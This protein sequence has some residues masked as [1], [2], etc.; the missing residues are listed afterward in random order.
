MVGGIIVKLG[1]DRCARL[2]YTIA[3]LGEVAPKVFTAVRRKH[4]AFGESLQRRD[5]GSGGTGTRFESP[6]LRLPA[7][8]RIIR[9]MDDEEVVFWRYFI[10][11][12]VGGGRTGG[13]P[14]IVHRDNPIKTMMDSLGEGHPRFRKV[15]RRMVLNVLDR[16]P[17]VRWTDGRTIWPNEGG[18]FLNP[19]TGEPLVQPETQVNNRM[20]ILE[21]GSLLMQNFAHLHQNFRPKDDPSRQIPI[22]Q[23]DVK[24]TT[25]GS[26]KDTKRF[27]VATDVWGPLPK[28]L[29][30]L[31]R[32]DLKEVTKPMPNESVQR[33][34]D[35]DD[36]SDVLRDLGW[37]RVQPLW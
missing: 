28:E 27:A 29:A 17:I 6:Y 7:G 13:K 9:I 16:T 15:E 32:Y 3:T 21:L 34:L 36:Y 37:E 8:E 33:L 12:N 2:C 23:V 31:P 30:N 35:G 26:G 19:E 10:N 5:T 25:F 22:Q 11:V 18:I 24:I 1:I 20:Y 4:M 14:I